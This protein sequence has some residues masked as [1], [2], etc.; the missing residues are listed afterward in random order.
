MKLEKI[1]TALT[2]FVCAMTAVTVS[3]FAVSEGVESS[4]SSDITSDSVSDAETDE[5]TEDN[6]V[7]GT[8][9][10]IYTWTVPAA[11]DQESG[12]MTENVKLADLIGS[13]NP[14]DI[15]YIVIKGANETD[16]VGAGFNTTL[17]DTK[18]EGYYQSPE[19]D[20]SWPANGI[21]VKGSSVDWDNYFLQLISDRGDAT[22][23]TAAIYTK[24][25]SD[26]V[27]DGSASDESD[28]SNESTSDDASSDI[29]STPTESSSSSESSSIP[30]NPIPIGSVS[31]ASSA[32]ESSTP[33]NSTSSVSGTLASDSNTANNNSPSGANP[34][35]GIAM[36]FVPAVIAGAVVIAAKKRK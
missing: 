27:N 1:L 8:P 17:T 20:E 33:S 19:D 30:E 34:T 28:E 11:E 3:A 29:S 2:A 6:L 12:R 18:A 10:Y 13:V 4:E 32:P 23:V 24:A 15:D 31:I 25:N 14:E 26:N 16:E 35:T 9:V 7:E 21:T 36:A 22:T 5:S